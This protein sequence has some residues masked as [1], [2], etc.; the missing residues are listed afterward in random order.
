METPA[1][2]SGGQ[3]EVWIRRY[4]EGAL[5][6]KAAVNLFARSGRRE[7]ECWSSC[8]SEIHVG[9][10]GPSIPESKKKTPTPKK[11][12]QPPPPPMRT[13]KIKRSE[14]LWH[15]GVRYSSG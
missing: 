12:H 14:V 5:S 8:A 10:N 13:P 15:S 2:Q 3:E 1:A 4:T 7:Y 6:E 9:W 11:P